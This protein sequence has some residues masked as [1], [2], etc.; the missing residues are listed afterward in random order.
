MLEGCAKCGIESNFYLS[1]DSNFSDGANAV[2]LADRNL[3]GGAHVSSI[4][5]VFE[6]RGILPN[7]SDF[8]SGGWSYRK[9][10]T[11]NGTTAGYQINYQMKL[12]VH[13]ST[14]TDTPGNVYLNGS[15]GSDFGDLRFTKSDGV[16]L[17]DHWIESYTSGVSATVWVEID[18][19]PPS[20]NNVSIY[21]YYGNPGAASASSGTATFDLFDDFSGSSLDTGKWNNNVGSTTVSGG[22]LNLTGAALVVSKT[23]FSYPRR[24]VTRAKFVSDLGFVGMVNSSGFSSTTLHGSRDSMDIYSHTAGLYFGS[25]KDNAYSEVNKGTSY[26]DYGN[27]HVWEF[28]WTNSSIKLIRDGSLLH[29]KSDNVPIIDL[30]PAL[31]S[32]RSSPQSRMVVDYALVRKYANPEPAWT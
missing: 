6:N 14:G 7:N 5:A 20:P 13:N 24:M 9:L 27:F 21:L 4:E 12:T 30:Y 1:P 18:Y 19:I 31:S 10:K 32:Y 15:A 3:Y 11:I 23:G 8:L 22:E 16:T 26:I 17:L 2:I 25:R 29:T 28:I